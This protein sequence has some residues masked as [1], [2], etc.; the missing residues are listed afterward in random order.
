MVY[1]DWISQNTTLSLGYTLQTDT[2]RS[3]TQVLHGGS[4]HCT[5]PNP[6]MSEHVMPCSD[7]DGGGIGMKP[8]KEFK[9]TSQC[10]CARCKEEK[11]I[12]P[13][14]KILLYVLF[15]RESENP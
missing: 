8:E 4:G 14:E 7:K 1:G 9:P 13:G 12:L 11:R 10:G 2:T 6:M 3:N 15:E 5:S